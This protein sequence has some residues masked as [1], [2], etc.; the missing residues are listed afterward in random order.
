MENNRYITFKGTIKCYFLKFYPR[1]PPPAPFPPPL[2]RLFSLAVPHRVL[3][4]GL[5]VLYTQ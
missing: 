4:L 5:R 1:K 2:H 3:H